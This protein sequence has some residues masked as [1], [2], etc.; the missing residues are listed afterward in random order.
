MVLFELGF[1]LLAIKLR[2]GAASIFLII[3]LIT[4]SAIANYRGSGGGFP[5]GGGGGLKPEG[6]GI[7][8]LETGGASPV[9]RPDTGTRCPF[10]Y[11]H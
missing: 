3:Q 11:M 2:I 1:V 6:A 5:E 4:R 9:I 8:L 10:A 7:A